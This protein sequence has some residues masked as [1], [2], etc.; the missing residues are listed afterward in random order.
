MPELLSIADEMPQHLIRVS[1]PRVELDHLKLND[2]YGAKS[3]PTAFGDEIRIAAVQ[4]C[5]HR[6]QSHS[7]LAVDMIICY[8]ETL[9]NSA[10]GS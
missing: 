3:S 2:W 5:G 1:R 6:R 9:R 8:R 4:Y 10:D 7:N